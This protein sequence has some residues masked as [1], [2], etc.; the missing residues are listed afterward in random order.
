[1]SAI[2]EPRYLRDSKLHVSIR[3]NPSGQMA[4]HPFGILT[5]SERIVPLEIEINKFGNQLPKD[6]NRFEIK[7][8]DN[9]L[10]TDEAREQFAPANFLR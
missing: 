4:V 3:T 5:F 1:M 8:N 2:G 9:D 7:V 10:K 6:T